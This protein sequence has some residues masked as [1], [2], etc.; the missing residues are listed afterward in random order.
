MSPFRRATAIAVW[1]LAMSLPAFA[2][3]EKV[4]AESSGI[5]T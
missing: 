1:L 2:Q 4:V 5:Q 3:L